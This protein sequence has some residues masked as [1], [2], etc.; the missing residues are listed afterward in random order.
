MESVVLA[1]GNIGQMGGRSEFRSLPVGD[2]CT[3]TQG[4]SVNLKAARSS[5][6][7]CSCSTE[8][9]MLVVVAGL[10]NM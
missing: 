10:C 5:T 6:G 3:H 7:M 4:L 1:A 8:V 2:A 9:L